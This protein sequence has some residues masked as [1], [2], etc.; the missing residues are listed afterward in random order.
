LIRIV[1]AEGQEILLGVIGSLLNLEDDME[2]VGQ[3][4]NGEDLI[5]LVHQV[6]PD[7][8]IMDIEMPIKSGLEAAEELKRFGYKVI[9]LTTFART[10]NVERALDADVR[11]YLIKDAPSEELACA[12]RRV[13]EGEQIY[14]SELTDEAS[15]HSKEELSEQL[16]V[17]PE[18]NTTSM[19]R[20]YI[21]TI[22]KKM[23]QQAG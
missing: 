11:G 1:I 8:C 16:A 19:V 20:H 21:S 4:G 2:V 17:E 7:V 10:G 18:N 22:I 9:L 23:K 6:Q 13:F 14:S 5:K 12:V 3:A 15:S